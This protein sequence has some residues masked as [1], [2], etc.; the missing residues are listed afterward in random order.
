MPIVYCATEG[1]IVR[2]GKILV[3]RARAGNVEFY[4]FPGGRIDPDEF[5][6]PY[7]DIIKRELGEEIGT[8]VK[9]KLILKPVSFSRHYYFS[10]R[11]NKNIR[12]L[13]LFFEAEYLGG[14]IKISPEHIGC[15]WLDLAQMKID[16]YFTKGRLEGVKRYL[17]LA[18]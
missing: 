13:L 2:N 8:G 1:V 6:T 4:D 16:K 18:P 7:E 12:I 11:Q 3:L 9:Y 17:D 14:K 10:E 5:N 15:D